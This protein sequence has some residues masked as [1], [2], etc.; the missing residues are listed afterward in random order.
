MKIF[1]AIDIKDK[2][3]VRL[4]KG[5]FNNKTEYQISPI[6]QAKSYKDHGFKY[7]HIVDLDGA[8][9]GKT[10]NLDIIQEI[11]SKSALKIEI[12]GGIRNFKDIQKYIDVG[13][14]KVI[15]GS[16]A[17]KDKNFLKEACQKFSKQ[18]ALG[19]DA[20]NGKLNV[21]G[22]KESSNKSTLEFLK[23]VNNYGVSRLIFTDINKDGT[24]ESPNFDETSK[25]ADI[26]NCPVIISGGVS[27]IDDVKKAKS[28][29]N[30][31]GII[32]GKALYDGDI[33]LEE[34]VKEDA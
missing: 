32:V 27:S 13:V 6:D 3:C 15:L 10:V 16:A 30:I 1:P 34:L 25:V 28:L 11:V 23:E 19:L 24:K 26:S 29:R 14:E 2:K 5:D 31:E 20:K 7:L 12:G 21:S 17:I 22:W 33:K 4:V 9:T 8:L 18:I